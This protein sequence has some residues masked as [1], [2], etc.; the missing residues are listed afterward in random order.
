[1]LYPPC[2]PVDSAYSSRRPRKDEQE[3]FSYARDG[4][5]KGYP[6]CREE[7]IHHKACESAPCKS[8]ASACDTENAAA[9]EAARKYIDGIRKALQRYGAYTTA[10]VRAAA[11]ILHA[12][13]HSAPAAAADSRCSPMN[14]R[15][16]L[17]PRRFLCIKN[18]S[19]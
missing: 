5:C 4:A 9:A 10:E 18:T 13:P 11:A 1:M 15:R 12:P 16:L 2:V 6:R 7:N 19:A 8:P 17:L 14:S 3:E